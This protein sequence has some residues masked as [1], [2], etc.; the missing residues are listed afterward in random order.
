MN[1]RRGFWHPKLSKK[2]KPPN[3][4]SCGVASLGLV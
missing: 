2:N 1:M 4:A 3:N